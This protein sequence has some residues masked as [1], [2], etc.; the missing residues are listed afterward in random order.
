MLDAKSHRANI[1]NVSREPPSPISFW[2]ISNNL[3]DTTTQSN[4]RYVFCFNILGQYTFCCR[5]EG[6]HA[7]YYCNLKSFIEYFFFVICVCSILNKRFWVV[8]AMVF[9]NIL[10]ATWLQSGIHVTYLH[11]WSV[12]RLSVKST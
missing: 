6:E 5:I 1:L 10:F 9:A 11:L 12:S 2:P 3:H 7:F 4:R 8:G